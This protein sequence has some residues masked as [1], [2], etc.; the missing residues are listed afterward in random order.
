MQVATFIQQLQADAPK[1]RGLAAGVLGLVEEKRAFDTIKAAFAGETHADC[2][3]LL[4]WA[5]KRLVA[6][7]E[8]GYD[9]FEDVLE[10]FGVNR[11]IQA[12]VQAGMSAREAELMRRVASSIQSS[13]GLS[14]NTVTTVGRSM[15]GYAMGGFAGAALHALSDIRASRGHEDAPTFDATP[16]RAVPQMPTTQDFSE[17]LREFLQAKDPF[18]QQRAIVKLGNCNNP[19]VLPHLVV[20]FIKAQDADV[21]TSIENVARGLYLGAWYYQLS[22]EGVIE[23]E[24]EKRVQATQR[25]LKDMTDADRNDTGGAAVPE[26]NR[27]SSPEEIASILKKAEQKKRKRRR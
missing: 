21:R 19:A 26:E 6:A 27:E 2:R 13:D 11:D 1:T 14:M 5:G 8:R 20:P 9:T 12:Q 10:R 16:Q 7:H 4:D 3:K 23:R 25:Q 24:I 17:P 18:A 22:Q 15:M